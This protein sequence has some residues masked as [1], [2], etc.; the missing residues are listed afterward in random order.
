MCRL[1]GIV[2][3]RRA[4]L[5]ELLDDDLD[6]FLRLACVHRDGWGLAYA[7]ATDSVAQVKEPV[8]A[9]ESSRFRPVVDCC[10]TDAAILHLRLASP[11]LAVCEG[12]THPFGDERAAFA[13]NGA[14]SPRE[15]LD[16][17]IGP[18]RLAA[19]AGD[20]DSERYYQ[21]V[22][23]RMDDGA[24]PGKAL[25]Q[26]AADI[27]ARA[28][29]LVSLNCLLLAGDALYAYCDHDPASEVIGRRGPDFFDLHYRVDADRVVVASTGWPQPEARWIRLAPRHVLRIDRRDLS[30]E[31]YEA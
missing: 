16:P 2:S 4:A 9:E 14:F 19:L 27:R 10:I 31:V 1:L 18:D 29:Q 28:D 12:N 3:S 22:R 25:A 20:T 6:A 13:H 24:D 23:R 5:S 21:A 30:T 15:L 8:N 26:T 17:R 11:N 7:D